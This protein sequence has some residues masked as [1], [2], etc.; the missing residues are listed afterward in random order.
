MTL[1]SITLTSA[2]PEYSTYGEDNLYREYNLPKKVNYVKIYLIE[3]LDTT[4]PSDLMIEI[5]RYT[6][7]VKKRQIHFSRIRKHFLHQN[8]L[9]ILDASAFDFFTIDF[10]D[11]EDFALKI[12]TSGD[13]F[14]VRIYY[15]TDKESKFHNIE[16][17]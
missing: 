5:L 1:N 2:N 10:V 6:G 8:G 4:N 13:S 9:F 3:I 16:L 17:I 11:I 12:Y 7:P 14:S 15:E